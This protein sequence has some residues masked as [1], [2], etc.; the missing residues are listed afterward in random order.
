MP[1]TIVQEIERRAAFIRLIDASL[2]KLF[3]IEPENKTLKIR[4]DDLHFALF[5][6]WGL[7]GSRG[8]WRLKRLIKERLQLREV[9]FVSSSGKR[10]FRGIGFKYE[11]R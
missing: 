2:D 10:F 11:S 9:Q 1:R 3:I 8:N 4:R 5:N 6:S 7:T